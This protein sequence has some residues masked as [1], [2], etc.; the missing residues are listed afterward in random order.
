MPIKSLVDLASA[1][2]IKNIRILDS[3][4]DYLPYENVRHILARVENA[5]QL[6]RI[7]LNSPQIEGRTGEIWLK[8]I[9]RDFPLEY[10]NKAYKPQNPAKWYRVW[11]R[12][13]KDHDHAVEESVKQFQSAFAGLRQ[14]REKNTSKIVEG[15]LLPTKG[16]VKRRRGG[17]Q[18]SDRLAFTSG[19]KT[20]TLNGAGVMRKVRREVKEIKSIHGSLSRSTDAVNKAQGLGRVHH[21]PKGMVNEHRIAAQPA[22]LPPMRSSATAAAPKKSS[23][24]KEFEARATFISDSEDDYDDHGG[25][26]Y[27]DDDEGDMENLFDEPKRAPAPRRPEPEPRPRASISG[28]S[29]A[30]VKS[31][32]APSRSPTKA[33][34]A[35]KPT[36]ASKVKPTTASPVK[37]GLAGRMAQKFGNPRIVKK[38]KPAS[39]T[40]RPA[41]AASSSSS[42]TKKA[43]RETSPP[44]R[45]SSPPAPDPKP[46]LAPP[47]KR[48][49]VD[50]FMRPKKRLP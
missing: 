21:A 48:K 2:C 20:K 5:H 6:R 13:K 41:T 33:D 16:R 14:D 50:V 49:A 1:A 8:M 10:R 4:G 32:P 36:T 19:S 46:T 17:S 27:D 31:A 40:S 39:E 45:A 44:P 42:P 12:Y 22:A 7:E 34:A 43:G 26:D 15:H 3:V 28:A 18:A 30:P 37:T 35:P 47:R 29:R 11:E 24:V 25:N 23:I 38:A 9:E